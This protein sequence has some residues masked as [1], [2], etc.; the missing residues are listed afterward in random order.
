[1]APSELLACKFT[2]TENTLQDGKLTLVSP[3]YFFQGGILMNIGGFMEL[4]LG[5]TFPCIVFM[6]FGTFWLSFGGILN[7]SFAAWSSYAGTKEPA[8]GLNTVG[9]NSSLGKI[10]LASQLILEH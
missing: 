2:N 6:T 4:I 8:T 10:F 1:M 7:P 3:V 9:F 5:N